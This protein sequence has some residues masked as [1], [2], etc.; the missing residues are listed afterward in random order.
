M[1]EVH[2]VARVAIRPRRDDALRRIGHARAA[3]ASGDA[4]VADQPILQVSPWQQRCE[5]RIHA[6]RAA[7]YEQLRGDDRQRIDDEGAVR[8]ALEP[9]TQRAFALPGHAA[10]TFSFG[11][12]SLGPMPGGMMKM[13]RFATTIVNARK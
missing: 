7:M 4:I 1:P 10:A 12:C 2:R 6:D 11:A 8:G 3:A 9:A 13:K 5:P